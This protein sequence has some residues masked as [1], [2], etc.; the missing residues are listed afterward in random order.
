MINA[1]V[2]IH[3][4]LLCF[5]QARRLSI[6]LSIKQKQWPFYKS[7]FIGRFQKD[8]AKNAVRES[9][10]VQL[11]VALLKR[12]DPKL[13]II[14]ADCLRILSV[15]NQPTKM[16]I[17]QVRWDLLG[18]LMNFWVKAYFNCSKGEGPT[19]LV[20]IMKKKD[21]PNLIL[22]TARLLKGIWIYF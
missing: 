20:N 22:M 15:K 9:N 11:M 17:L 10:G 19:L 3:S 4:L 21:Y 13:L 8:V 16:I 2:T 7:I 1:L 5:D 14:I 12:D 6:W 18:L